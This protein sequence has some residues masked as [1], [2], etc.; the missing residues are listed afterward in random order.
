MIKWLEECTI[1]DVPLVGGKSASLGEL[2]KAGKQVPPGFSITVNAYRVFAD[3][4]GVNQKLNE[5]LKQGL[6]GMDEAALEQVK[7][8]LD[9]YILN[10]R[11]PLQVESAVRDAYQQLGLR[12]GGT[13]LVAVRSSATMED[14][15]ATSFAGQH[16]TFLN[17]SGV[18]DVLEKT[19][20]CWASLFSVHALHYRSSKE[21][22]MEQEAMAVVVQKMVNSKASGVA[23]TVDPVSGDRS[24]VVI[25][26]AWGLGEGIV[27]GFVTP[28]H[29]VVDKATLE[30]R[31][32]WISPKL[33]EFI[34]HPESG[35]TVQQEVA[36]DRQTASSLTNMEIKAIA[37][38]AMSIEEHYGKPQ[39]IEWA[40]DKDLRFPK[41]LL[42]LQSRPVTVWGSAP[43]Q[44]KNA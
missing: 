32:R 27:G 29:F 34:R 33:T 3:T 38:A 44:V 23:F 37:Q 2:S 25:D 43:G 30:I 40:I 5:I 31:E 13:P 4:S 11:L 7:E 1:N 19:L 15:S 42:I 12:I 39:D 20:K 8:F 21:I 10:A 22:S 41:N 14:S 28:D 9:S 18:E 6:S 26:A 35:E 17:V 36:K 16:E 24:K